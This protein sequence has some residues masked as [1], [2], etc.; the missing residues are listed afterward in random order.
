VSYA[1]F[2]TL[3]LVFFMALY[4]VSDV[5]ETKLATAASS[6]RAAFNS[7]EP[8]EKPVPAA[9]KPHELPAPRYVF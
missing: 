6:L 9:P 5:N 3:L 1:D 4:T 2:T 7:Q 8:V